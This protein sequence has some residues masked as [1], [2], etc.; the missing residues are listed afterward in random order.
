MLGFV[1]LGVLAC[2]FLFGGVCGRGTLSSIPN[3]VVKAFCAD[4]TALVGVWESRS[5]P[6]NLILCEE[7]GEKPLL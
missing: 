1:F 7:K 4:G 3:L 6:N 2:V 5:L